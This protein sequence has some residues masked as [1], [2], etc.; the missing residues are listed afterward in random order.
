VAE[1]GTHRDAHTR[2]PNLVC[3]IVLPLL[4]GAESACLLYI[5][6]RTY[7][8]ADPN[9]GRKAR[10]TIALTQFEHGIVSGDYLLDLGTQLTR[11]T[12]K[13]ALE[14]LEDKELVEVRFSCTNC[15]WEQESEVSA[16]EAA[17][18][19]APRCPRC[20][21][22]L[23]RSWAMAQLTPA[24]L[25][26]FL[27]LHDKAR[28]RWSW[29]SERQRFR[30][31]SAEAAKDKARSREDLEA[32]RERLR[33]LVWYPELVEE[34][35]ALASAQLRSGSVSLNR[36]V[37]NFYKIVWELQEKYPSPPLVRYA[38][39]QTLKGP[40]LRQPKNHRWFRYMQA[41]AANNVSRF[42]GKPAGGEAEGVQSEAE[43][44]RER[45]LKMRDLLRRAAELNGSGKLEQ[46]RAL[47]SD[48]LGQV[49]QL[50]PLFDGNAELCENSLREA[51]KQGRS[52]FVGVQ[53]NPYGL[54]LY[55]EW[56]WPAEQAA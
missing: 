1:S 25:V 19:E 21:A 5:I 16:P 46:A 8:F 40:A 33:E 10:D 24:K 29:D 28:R 26:T 32:E 36:E 42:S 44:L 48:I 53:P 7:G 20:A 55:P 54:D 45:E 13:K 49:E 6:R 4:S 22:T 27:N 43:Q 39:E 11:N 2:V 15:L 9:G 14:G 18:G 35:I 17:D 34:M 56:S 37:S 30:F 3:D 41:V 52:D 23:S 50:A 51:F 38:L 31:E 12:I 47:L